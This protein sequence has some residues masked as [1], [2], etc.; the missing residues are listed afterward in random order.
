MAKKH[1]NVVT[2]DKIDHDALVAVLESQGNAL[3]P[4]V[5]A[6][7][8][9]AAPIIARIAIRYVARKVRRKVSDTTVN[10]ASQFV[11]R[12]VQTIIDQ[13]AKDVS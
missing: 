1:R 7:I 8:R 6:V 9:M 11:G 10:A 13:A 12:A 2:A 3:P 5:A 4:I